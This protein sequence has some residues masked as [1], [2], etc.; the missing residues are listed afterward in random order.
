MFRRARQNEAMADNIG[1]AMQN[2][3]GRAVTVDAR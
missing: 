2:L 3:T 1:P